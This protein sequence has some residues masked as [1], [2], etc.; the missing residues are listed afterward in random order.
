MTPFEIVAAH[1]TFPP[2]IKPHPLQIGAINRS[3]L[4]H[5]AGAWHSMGT[6]K[7]FMATATSLYYK[8]MHGIPTLVVMPPLLIR[9]WATWLRS[10]TPAL[11]V[12]EYRGTPAQR[13]DMSLDGDFIL[14]GIQIFK[15]EIDKF[16]CHFLN[17]P[18]R[19]VVDEATMLA[20]VESNNHDKVY[21]TAVGQPCEMLSGTPTNKPYDTYGLM[22]FTA[23]GV[24][25]NL[26][27][28]ENTH[29]EAFDYH[30]T[31]TEYKNL[32]LL[33]ENLMI[34]SERILLPDMYPDIEEP[35][36]IP[37]NYELAPAHYKL[38]RKLAEEEL[39]K[40]PD[41]GKID[42][43][44]ANK[45]RHALGQIIVNQGHFS[46]V[47]TDTSEAVKLIEHTLFELGNDKLVVFADYKLTVAVL[48]DKLKKYGAVAING[49]T[50]DN[51]K[52]K[53]INTFL[54]DKKC[55]VFIVN[56]ISGGKGL[57][58]LQHV[59]NDALFIEPCQQ[60]RDF[61]QCVARLARLGQTKKVRVKLAIAKGTTQVRGFKN[62]LTNDTLVN[63]VIRTTGELRKMIYGE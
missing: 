41:G 42:G 22:K 39:L 51:Q 32:D 7:T 17:R 33:R 60:P 21:E 34:N 43:T 15:K 23:P 63:Q 29:V 10:I 6:G 8:I 13:A 36:Y 45:L 57:D 12:V 5:N 46:G 18:F 2:F 40:L 16:Q 20:Y 47:P 48:K 59:C 58:G 31:P 30:K 62:L 25:R 9:Q 24:Y 27:H 28:F 19:L 38:Y 26:R 37:V 55:R 35:L 56:F 50:S 4:R 61:H 44:T 1:Y 49:E 3:S 54:T 11:K 53:N 52:A 14:V